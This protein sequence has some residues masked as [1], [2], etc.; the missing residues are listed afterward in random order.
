MK[1]LELAYRYYEQCGKPMIREKFPELEERIA[2]GLAGEGSE[3]FGFDDEYS[4]DHDWGPCFCMW[5][6]DED[7]EKAGKQLEEEYRNLAG[8][9]EGYA[10][11][12]DGKYAG[13]RIGAQRIFDYYYQFTGLREAPQ[14]IAQWRRIPEEFLATATN[15]QVFRDDLGVFTQRREALLTYYP[16][17]VRLKKLSVRLAVMA[18]AGQYNYGRSRKRNEM[19]AAQYALAE[20]MRAACSAVYLLN[21]KYMPYYKW[22]HH[23][24]KNL[25][26]LQAVYG[27]LDSLCSTGNKED[28]I[29]T[30][31]KEIITE[32][33]KQGLSDCEDDFLIPQAESVAGKIRDENLKELHLMAE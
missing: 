19:V 13:G 33:K 24:M 18:Q 7:Y 27:L 2:C 29:E 20:F 32:L 30:V 11:R 17:D 10:P 9:F 22:A 6:C 31:C 16:E 21:K 23:G 1:G 15:G 12:K 25:D 5:L 4:R 26:V 3:C 28:E 14:T 8:F